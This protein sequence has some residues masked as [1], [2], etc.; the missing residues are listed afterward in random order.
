MTV[1]LTGA[2][3]YLGSHLRRTLDLHGIEHRTVGSTPVA[4]PRSSSRLDL[5]EA[6]IEDLTF[7]L[8]ANAAT[9]LVHLAAVTRTTDAEAN[10]TR[11]LDLNVAATGRLLEACRRAGVERFVFASTAL[12][13]GP[14]DGGLLNTDTDC[15]PF[16]VYAR[17]KRDAEHLVAAAHGSTLRTVSLRLTSL[18]G[19]TVT[20]TLP[21]GVV[22]SLVQAR[23]AGAPVTLQRSGTGDGTAVRDFLDVGDAASA[24]VAVLRSPLPAATSTVFNVATDS[25]RSLAAV[26]DEICRFLGRGDAVRFEDPRLDPVPVLRPDA[27][28]F[29]TAFGW[30]PRTPFS[31]TLD[32]LLRLS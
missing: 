23:R 17:S 27:N 11:C 12:V 1:M 9:A 10:P 13:Y 7:E 21:H 8:R 31:T 29:R 26:D 15:R 22:S 4:R 24:F 30:E 6:S 28:S 18:F 19:A 5:L 16:G 2:T 25:S 32:R 20:G 14:N 3:G